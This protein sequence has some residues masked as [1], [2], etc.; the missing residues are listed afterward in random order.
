MAALR[1]LTHYV[2]LVS[3]RTCISKEKTPSY[4]R[5]VLNTASQVTTGSTLSSG[6]HQYDLK[7]KTSELKVT[8]SCQVFLLENICKRLLINFYIFP[9][10]TSVI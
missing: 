9:I 6:N 7:G 1:S 10:I 4:L 2:N 8:E 3:F 5:R